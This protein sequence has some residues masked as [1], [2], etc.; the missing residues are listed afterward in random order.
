MDRRDFLRAV[1]GLGAAALG[2]GGCGLDDADSP[3]LPPPPPP[4]LAQPDAAQQ[5][6]VEEPADMTMPPPRQTRGVLI[7]LDDLSLADWPDRAARAGLTALSLHCTQ[8]PSE[9]MVPFIQGP[10]GQFFLERCARLGLDVEF[11]MHSMRDLMP[12]DLFASR[13]HLFRANAACERVADGNLCVHSAEALDVAAD[14]AIKLVRAL[15]STTSRYFLWPDDGANW[16]ECDCCAPLSFS[17]QQLVL[18]NHMLAAIRSVDSRAT[19][20]HLAYVNTL[21]A[22]SEIEPADGM[23]LEF[24]PIFRRYDLA[25][26]TP[27]DE[28]QRYYLDSL[29][30]NLAVFNK[31]DAKA[32]EFWLDVSRFSGW[33][34]PARELPFVEELLRADVRAYHA[35]GVRNISSFAAWLDSDYVK[36]FG[37]PPLPE[38]G[39]AL[40]Q[41]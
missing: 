16:C 26:D 13:P 4:P 30:A 38:F 5:P 8:R 37:E 7:T 35:R 29:D 18:E 25:F 2:A 3:G 23:F 27:G 1:G 34:R 21:D 10:L 12:S 11:E 14:N 6:I 31:G 28:T 32:L 9:T 19:L 39:R 17:D 41:P 20:A 24:C 15:R 33:T 40:S 36:R 22:P